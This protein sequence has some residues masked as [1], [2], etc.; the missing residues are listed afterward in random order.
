MS[1]LS[2]IY[3]AVGVRI[4]DLPA[5]PAKVL[6]AME[7]KA[8]GEEYVPQRYYLGSDFYDTVDDIKANPL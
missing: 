7:A 3:D 5:T 2:A 6:A 8:R 4:Y 1:V